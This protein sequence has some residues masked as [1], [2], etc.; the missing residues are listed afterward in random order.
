[1][2]IIDGKKTE[3]KRVERENEKG[4]SNQVWSLQLCMHHR[5]RSCVTVHFLKT[6]QH[7]EAHRGEIVK[8][9]VTVDLA[10][11]RG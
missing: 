6:V 5:P 3:P 1:M 7:S 10:F 2:D 11:V 8:V 9:T 4:E